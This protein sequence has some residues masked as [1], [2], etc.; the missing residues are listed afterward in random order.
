MNLR[1]LCQVYS[2]PAT[3]KISC[4]KTERQLGWSMTFHPSVFYCCFPNVL[5]KIK[6]QIN[7]FCVSISR[8][9]PQA[10]GRFCSLL[11]TC[12][13]LIACWWW[14]LRLKTSIPSSWKIYSE[15]VSVMAR[16]QILLFLLLCK[17]RK[18]VGRVKF[19]R[20]KKSGLESQRDL[21]NF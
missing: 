7:P 12:Q 11:A 17:S 8:S 19:G 14:L 6:Y 3:G 20:K 16:K 1:H 5:A 4:T 13:Q 10:M 15:V 21:N 18:K 9:H 2:H